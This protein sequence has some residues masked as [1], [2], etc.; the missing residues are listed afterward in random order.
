VADP[1]R[2][3]GDDALIRTH[4]AN[5]RTFLAWVRTAIVLIAAGVAAAALT[6]LEGDERT[7]V[8]ALGALASGA[9]LAL[10]GVA[11]AAYRET[12]RQIEAGR[13]E[14][15]PGLTLAAAALTAGVAVAGLVFVAIEWAG[16]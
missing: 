1:T 7:A 16:D 12:R 2:G 5:E 15:S 3:T 4:L 13:Y 14:P 11:Y 8:L 9:G 10:V 6:D